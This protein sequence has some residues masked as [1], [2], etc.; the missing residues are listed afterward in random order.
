MR[1]SKHTNKSH[2]YNQE[3][4]IT[5]LKCLLDYGIR[6]AM[7]LQITTLEKVFTVKIDILL[8]QMMI[9]M[10]NSQMNHMDRVYD[11]L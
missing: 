10:V 3:D 4:M 1:D 8:T 5:L 7:T 9:S 11:R 2:S 6:P